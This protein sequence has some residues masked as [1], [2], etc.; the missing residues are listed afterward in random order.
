MSNARQT[1]RH[2]MQLTKSF[3]A[4]A[5]VATALLMLSVASS[6]AGTL[7]R[8]RGAGKLTIGYRTD[9]RPFSYQEASGPPAG[10][11]IALCG[12]VAETLKTELGSS[13]FAI[14]YVAVTSED[15]F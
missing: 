6:R 3:G 5:W 4:L 7:E 10:Y 13:A 8:I 12:K 14:E 2:T 1:R 11:S 15:R 9:T